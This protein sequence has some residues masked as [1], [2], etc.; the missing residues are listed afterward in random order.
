[1]WELPDRSLGFTMNA[2]DLRANKRYWKTLLAYIF[3]TPHKGPFAGSLI[4]LHDMKN[5][6]SS[7][8]SSEK[9]VVTG[10]G[11]PL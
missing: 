9:S 6:R 10:F 2:P 11:W 7:R 8:R 3:A 4:S 1:M 5:T